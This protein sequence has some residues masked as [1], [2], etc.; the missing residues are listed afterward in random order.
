MHRFS[1]FI[2]LLYK[3]LNGSELDGVKQQD[4][5]PQNDSTLSFKWLKKIPQNI[6]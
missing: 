6:V 2:I 3:K 5:T 1:Y 4:T